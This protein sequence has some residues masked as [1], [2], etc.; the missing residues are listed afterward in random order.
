VR[1]LNV[2]APL[3]TRRRRSGQ[4][5]IY[6]LSDEARKAKRRRRR[7][8]RRYRCTELQPDKQAYNAIVCKQSCLLSRT[9]YVNMGLH[10]L[11][12]QSGR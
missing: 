10:S 7:L 11:P 4:H 6:V 1:I 2:H 8:E 5:D 9:H 12:F 3:R